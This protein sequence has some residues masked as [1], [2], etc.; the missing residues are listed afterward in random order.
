M[1]DPVGLDARA[2]V[3]L[4]VA[5]GLG[6][7][8]RPP[9]ALGVGEALGPQH[10]RQLALRAGAAWCWGNNEAGQLGTAGPPWSLEALLVES[11]WSLAGEP[12]N[13]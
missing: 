7:G 10:S 11:D 9:R 6:C 13:E 12:T 8:P 1:R 3:L 5:L 2:T 4:L